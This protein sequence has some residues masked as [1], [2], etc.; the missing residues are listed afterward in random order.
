MPVIQPIQAERGLGGAPQP[1][2]QRDMSVPRA[3]QGLGNALGNA[4]QA[5]QE[6][7]LRRQQMDMKVQDFRT[8]QNFRQFN[9]GL[10]SIVDDA[11]AKM[12]P[13]G[14]GLTTHFVEQ[15]DKKSADF[16]ATVPGALK[17]KF[18]E[19]LQTSRAQWVDKV[20]HAEREQRYSW[21]R[22]GISESQEKLKAQVFND[23]AVYDA[24]KADGLRA[25]E[26][27]GLP[28]AEKAALRKQWDETLALTIGER[29]V[30]DAQA[31]P[32][33]AAGAAQRYGVPGAANETV[34]ARIIGAESGGRASA[35]NPNSSAS[36]VG[37]FLDSTWVETVKAHRPD[38][39]KGKTTQQILAL[40]ND[41][42]LGREMTAAYTKDNA[43]FLHNQGIE[44]T[45][46]NVYLAHFLGPRGAAVV[47]KADPGTPISQLVDENVMRANPFLKGKSASEVAAW[48]AKKM[49]GEQGSVSIDPRLA[50]LPLSERLKLYDRTVAAAKQG[51]AEIDAQRKTLQDQTYDNLRLGIE[52]GEVVSNQTIL[53][54]PYID[55]GQKA[56][57]IGNLRT[58]LGDDAEVSAYIAAWAEGS[59]AAKINPFD[60]NEAALNNKAFDK[61]MKTAPEDQRQ[62]ITEQFVKSTGNIP[63]ATVA[64]VRQG[65]ASSNV[66]EVAEGMEKAARLYQIAPEAMDAVSNGEELK[67][68]ALA[69]N[70]FVYGRGMTGQ[71]AGQRWL[72]QHSPE[73]L[74]RKQ[75]L[76]E[77]AKDFLKTLALSDVT[78]SFDTAFSF[79]PSAGLTVEQQQ[80]VMTD[81]SR[82]AEEKFIATGGDADLAKKLA[83]KDMSKLYGVS[84]VAGSSTLMK[85]PPERY[86]PA[87]N[88]GWDYVRDAAMQDAKSIDDTA[89]NVMLVPTKET[90]DDIRTKQPPRY[91]LFFQRQD[92]VW[93]EAAGGL[94]RVP[95]E[96]ISSGMEADRM[97]RREEA[98][99]IHDIAVQEKNTESRAIAAGR[100]ALDQTVGPDWMKARAADAATEQARTKGEIQ[101]PEITVTP[102]PSN[103]DLLKRAVNDSLVNPVPF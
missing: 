64:E 6:M 52:T 45:A 76:K 2:V 87:I 99:R 70:E 27:S 11:S 101:L 71:G 86:Y 17:P 60:S 98:R 14:Q 8:D 29:D 5:E 10:G 54:S 88:G 59:D 94:F 97:K 91:R 26:A 36:G 77:P 69:Y 51:Q 75:R 74:E 34:V 4:A 42:V 100:K 103:L 1:S 79:E 37:Q 55:E 48:A 15:F 12:D 63:K 92:G 84:E 78:N 95:A 28:D 81:Y 43:E 33:S 82:I 72:D 66:A 67:D 7:N 23:P 49:G 96:E 30:R 46:G 83:L 25:I 21:F 57:L 53:D 3:V 56:A 18:S 24:A 89:L 73:A 35:K 62:A 61:I 40:K 32:A 50:A 41:P 58:R 65:L 47:L 80:A 44:T 85:Y 39:A 9:E 19:L 22:T 13:S 20:A 16:L 38:I 68:A 102:G 31:N 93:D 90:A